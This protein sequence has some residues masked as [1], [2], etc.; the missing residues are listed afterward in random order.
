MNYTSTINKTLLVILVLASNY[1]YAQNQINADSLPTKVLEQVVVIGQLDKPY[2]PDVKDMIVYSGKKTNVIN[3][4]NGEANLP[5]NLGRMIFAKMPGVNLWDMDGAGTQM[6]IGSRGTDAHRSIEMNMR[7]N[8]YN[9]NSDMFGYP[10]NH[11]AAPMQAISQIQLLRGSAALQFG[12]Q[13]GGMMNYVMK[14]GDPSKVFSL[15]SEQTVGSFNLF[16]SFN[17]VG[18]TKGKI[19]YYAYYDNRHSDGWRP[20]GSYRY[21]AYYANIKFM[22]SKKGSISFQFS[23][24][25]TEQQIAGGLTD[26]QFQ[27]NAKQSNRARNYFVPI[28]NVP[29]IIFN[30][31]LSERTNLQITTNGIFGERSSVQFINTPNVND[32]INTNLGTYNPR[33][34]DRDFYKGFTTEA[35]VLH[36]YQIGKVM[37][38]L[39]GGFR[40]FNQKTQRRQKGKGTTGSDNDMSLLAPYGIDLSFHTINY[41]A[42]VEN[43]FKLNE[44]FSVTPGFRYEIIGSNLTGVIN[45]ATLPVSYKGDRT[46]PLF[47]L[48]LQFQTTKVTQLYGNIS[49]A[50][51]PYLYANVTPA[52]QIGVIDPNLKDSKGYDIDFGYRGQLY[53][54]LSF[55]VNAFYLFYGDKIGKVTIKDS[56]NSSYQLTTNIGNS[57]AK[58]FEAYVNLSLWKAIGGGTKNVDLK[59]FSSLA[60]TKAR[61]ISGTI[62][63]NGDNISLV[64]NRVEGVPDWIERAGLEFRYKKISTTFQSSYV[65]DQFNDAN[66]TPSSITGVVGHVPAYTLFDWAFDW[67]FLELYHVSAGI[68]NLTDVL[69]FSRRINMYPGPGILP[70]DGRSFYI[71]FGFKM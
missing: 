8:G 64:G 16:N 4:N 65:S 48:G 14:E 7:Q 54:L 1:I 15:E 22:F 63:N 32:T 70:G 37:S 20:N 19:N 56:N 38:T 42:F 44:K 6:N 18:G 71:S 11:Y 34:V 49:Q 5:Q 67:K 29:A 68:N 55:D 69:Y 60:Y 10:E 23:R 59:I 47:G 31:A 52:D 26:E 58:G 33:Q 24:T 30:Y 17:A 40:Y 51:R 41:A 53:D 35:R 27:Q 50:Y 66:N 36:R 13:F 61:Y 62:I 21:K 9:T 3:L 25:D 28:I 57:I 39:A 46:F 45:N 43:I 12:S 2:L